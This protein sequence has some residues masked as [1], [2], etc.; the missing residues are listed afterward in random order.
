MSVET[1]FLDCVK[2]LEKCVKHMKDI[3][4]E[5]SELVNPDALHGIALIEE[6][7]EKIEHTLCEDIESE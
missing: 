1:E 7:L 2:Q 3:R 6:G 5:I 4:H